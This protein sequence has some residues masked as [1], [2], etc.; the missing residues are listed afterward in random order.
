MHCPHCQHEAPPRAKFC[1]ECG[2]SLPVACASCATPLPAK[3]KF[4]PECA[5]PVAV[6][7]TPANSGIAPR[8][9]SPA[10]YTPKHLAER[11]LTSKEALQGERKHVTVL[12]A[13][14]KGSMEL[15]ADRDPEDARGVLDTVLQTMM[16]AVHQYEG[17]VNQVMGDGIMAL[18]GA[19]LALEDHAVRASYAA[20]K[21]QAAVRQYA[22]EVHRTIG[23]PL[24]IRVG[25]NSGEV[26]VRS[27][28]NDLH[29]DY[30]AIGQTTHLAARMEQMAMPGS[31][32]IP[33]ETLALVE[34]YVVVRALGPRP[35][36]GLE[37]PV[38]VFEVSGASPIRSRLH[39]A[40]SRGLTRFVGR[41]SELEQ[42]ARAM[43]RAR[44]AQGQIVAVVGDPGVG[45]SRLYWEFLHSHHVDGWLVLESAS[46]S[47]GKATALLP[48]VEL[49]KGYFKVDDHD[50]ARTTREKVTG[51]L[52][53]LD[54]SL[55]GIL[56]PLLSVLGAP[57][58]DAQWEA[59]SASE[60]RQRIL[61]A[62]KRLVLRESQAQ[63]VIV[64]FEDLHWV[65]DETQTMLDSFV[66]SLPSA[67]VL[68][69]VNYRPEYR[70]AWGS[71]SYY[72]QLRID[73]L[74]SHNAAAL[75]DAL[76]GDA[77]AL[78]PLKRMLIARTE[79]NPFF[80]EESVRT[81]I[82]T[83]VIVGTPG[84]FQLVKSVETI[85]VPATVQAVLAARIDRLPLSVKH[86][87]QSAAVIGKEV[88]LP[89][90]EAVTESSPVDLRRE[91]TQLQAAE[92]L[93]EISLFPEVEYTFKHALT[94]EV[95]YQSLLRE[96]RRVLHERVLETLERR[97][98]GSG[99]ENIELLAH[100]AVR[101]DVWPR[102]AMYLFRAGARAQ[103]E[104]R[105][106]AATT[107]YTASLEALQRLGAGADRGLE[108]DVH[109]E[110]WSTRISTGQVEGL[111]ELGAKVE[112]LARALDDGPR[113]AR[114]Q[115]RQ[116]Q[117]IALSAA[118]PGTL[119]SAIDRARE[120]ARRADATDLRTRSYAQF[121]AGV[122]CRDL[123]R[124]GAALAEFDGGIRL[125]SAETAA[126]Q[127][128]GLVYPIYVS[129]CGWR[130]EA[131]AALGDLDAALASADDALRMAAEIK[132]PSSVSIA[133]A[134]LGYVYLMRGDV[135]AAVPVL[136]RGLAISEE[137]E[138]VHGICANG[139]YLAS[140]LLLSGRRAAGLDAL[141]RGLARP[142]GA[143]LQWTRFHT[144]TAAVYL[145]AG[146]APAARTEVARGLVA[147]VERE[148]RGYR[149]P[150]LRLDA[151]ILAADG[152]LDSA[153]ARVEEARALALEL[154]TRPELGHCHVTLAHISARAGDTTTAATH[155]ATAR[156]IFDELGVRL[157][158]ARPES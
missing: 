78:E 137:H 132:H 47:Y 107:F 119:H 70:H 140:A 123:G 111:S 60:R 124:I 15:L 84:A 31:I 112:A 46:A 128:P 44:T 104:A 11:I 117:A 129:L 27:I 3:A 62:V 61:D 21:M 108:L 7:P 33:P 106:A 130:A 22:E 134:F 9:A 50:D 96:R 35:V 63:P 74:A 29:M 82:E 135:D 151:E 139:L 54:E 85:Q 55:R 88:P 1:P 59:L 98:S 125:F 109:L 138:L 57:T 52:L 45:K 34:G 154:G 8:F 53:T 93:Y 155:D 147:S 145:M 28:G 68:L 133:N 56:S 71:R 72:T 32:L 148:A 100:H 118:I 97:M 110:L 30:T 143:L 113:L 79:G 120:A 36:K 12:F 115:V 37:E 101:G 142:R 42:L 102:A 141:A 95:A 43:S 17:T 4:C 10:A 157:W 105:Y 99:Q 5:H 156:K 153:R 83:R 116:A 91:L 150:L 16:D 24:H 94:L 90:L 20:L 103:A 25:L 73:P 131:R 114:V 2:N 89:L 75:L 144:V 81:L 6:S 49:L 149:A 40:A 136:E 14:L 146:Q 18:F 76:M 65:D 38:E 69:L 77:A 67:R 158:S 152:D 80:L 41:D 64:V 121:I 58:A 48:V 86:L 23:V 126:R 19:P 51:K 127:D 92:F 122:A 39:A 26:V 66:E 13:D 87:L